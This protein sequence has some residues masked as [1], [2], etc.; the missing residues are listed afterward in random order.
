M[1]DSRTRR[2]PPTNPIIIHE[3]YSEPEGDYDDGSTDELD[4][5]MGPLEDSGCTRSDSSDGDDDNDIEEN[6]AEDMLKF[7]ESFKGITKR[8]HLLNRIGEGKENH[9]PSAWK[10]DRL[11]LFH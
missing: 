5:S 7:E 4:E 2:A 8:Y 10:D 9:D 3:D 1:A 11:R 6:V